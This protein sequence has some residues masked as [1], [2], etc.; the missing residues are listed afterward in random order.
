[1]LVPDAMGVKNG[2]GALDA[3]LGMAS[4]AIE[5]TMMRAKDATRSCKYGDAKGRRSPLTDTPTGLGEPV[6]LES[7]L[8]ICIGTCCQRPCVGKGDLC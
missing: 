4:G 6:H 7:R 2:V 8:P 1:M 3:G 5:Y